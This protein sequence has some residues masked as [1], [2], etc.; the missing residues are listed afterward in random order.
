MKFRIIALILLIAQLALAQKIAVMDFKPRGEFSAQEVAILSDRFRGEIVKTKKFE[1]MERNEMSALDQELAVQMR[2][3][4]DPNV[5]AKAGLKVGAKY[6]VIGYM[7]R[8][9]TLY[10]IDVKMVNCE[11]S[12]IE[13]SFDEDYKG[14][15]EG[16][17]KIMGKMA[18]KMAGVE[19]NKT[20][21][22][23]GGTAAAALTGGAVYLLTNQEAEPGLPLP[24][25][26]PT[27]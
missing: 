25:T 24:P 4:F 23:I 12:Q 15:I 18:G 5:V 13:E 3:D 22:W 1:V 10:T 14:S 2:D 11:T 7:G 17:I 16:L 27:R 26:P 8:L 19:K 21:L 6:V 20:W 9:G